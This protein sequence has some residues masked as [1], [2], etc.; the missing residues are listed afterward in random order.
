MEKKQ[1]FQE[2]D[3]RSG[4]SRRGINNSSKQLTI[5]AKREK[6]P[7]SHTSKCYFRGLFNIISTVQSHTGEQGENKNQ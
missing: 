5:K 7:K 4:G 2:A 1:M 6:C 3:G